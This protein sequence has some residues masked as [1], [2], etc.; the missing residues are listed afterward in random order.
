MRYYQIIISPSSQSKTSFT[1]VVYSTLTALKT[2]NGS[3][4]AVDLDIFQSPYHQPTQNG[5][6][7]IRGVDFKD[8][9]QSA[10]FNNAR[11]QVSVGM[12]KGLP[13]AN[14]KQ[15]GLILDGTILQCFGNWLGSEVSLDMVIGA[16]SFNPN[17]DVNLSFEWLKNTDL[18]TAVTQCLKKAYPNTPVNGQFSPNLIYTEDQWGQYKNLLSLSQQIYAYSKQIIQDDTYLGATIISNSNGFFLNDGTAEAPKTTNVEFT[19]IVGN[20]T[21]LNIATIQAKLIMRSDLNVGDYIT[22]PKKTPVL[23]V[24][25]NFSQYRN[26]ISFQGKFRITQVRHVGSSRQPD[27]NSWCTVVDAVIP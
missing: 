5:Y 23:N 24:V 15:A 22:F 16:A 21:W 12:S 7:K 20:L 13:Y 19:D 11:I 6:V 1:P 27:G 4:L 14:P 25:N 10:N 9:N 26:N 8:L 18:T 3:A 17:V 2:D